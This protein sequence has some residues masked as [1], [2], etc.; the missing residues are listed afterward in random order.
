M[1]KHE[2]VWFRTLVCQIMRKF[3]KPVKVLLSEQKYAFCS[4]RYAL[5][6]SIFFNAVQKS[7]AHFRGGR[8]GGEGVC[9]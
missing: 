9:V 4:A 8:G 6:L 5:M 3:V 1:S 2:K 7:I